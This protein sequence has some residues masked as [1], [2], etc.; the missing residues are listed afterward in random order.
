MFT[1]RL[2]GGVYAMLVPSSRICPLLGCSKPAII[3]SVVV[4]PHPD[5]PSMEKN[6]PPGICRLMPSTAVTSL[7][8]LTRSTPSPS[9]PA[10]RHILSAWSSTGHL[11]P[12]SGDVVDGRSSAGLTAGEEAVDQ[13]A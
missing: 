5:G 13:D 2:C 3:R 8:S 6:S 10:T 1:L 11:D 7:N 9:P 4:L 12:E